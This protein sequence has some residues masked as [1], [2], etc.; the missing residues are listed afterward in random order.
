MNLK[1]NEFVE[2]LSERG[3][4]TAADIKRA[5]YKGAFAGST[6]DRLIAAGCI[7]YGA[8]L[9]PISESDGA[10]R[11]HPLR[12]GSATLFVR[13]RCNGMPEQLRSVALRLSF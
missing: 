1:V 5:G 12:M 3:K 8:A 2:W 7:V 10:T 13:R 11:A 4:V 9:A 6:R